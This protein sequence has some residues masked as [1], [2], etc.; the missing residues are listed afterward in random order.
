MPTSVTC[1]FTTQTFGACIWSLWLLWLLSSTDSDSVHPA[2][3]TLLKA[4][5]GLS[6]VYTQFNSQG[7]FTGIGTCCA[8]G[9][10][11]TNS[12][13][14]SRS[15]IR[16]SPVLDPTRLGGR[17]SQSLP[18]WKHVLVVVR[19]RMLSWQS[20]IPRKRDSDGSTRD[21][22]HHESHSRCWLLGLLYVRGHFSD[23]SILQQPMLIFI[24]RPGLRLSDIE[25]IIGFVSNVMKTL[26]SSSACLRSPS[27]GVLPPLSVF[28]C[29]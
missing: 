23:S 11:P 3:W 5:F 22:P 17:N 26:A 15:K 2:N 25:F 21:L 24:S 27:S 13:R 10:L 14:R 4:T 16:S 1:H 8:S 12:H 29:H 28:P 7:Q 18:R 19:T 20:K 6:T 9:R